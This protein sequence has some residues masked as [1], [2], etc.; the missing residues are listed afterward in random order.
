MGRT[1]RTG[2][3]MVLVVAILA[4]AIPALTAP[5]VRAQDW[6]TADAA[7]EVIA[8]SA[9]LLPQGAAEAET[10]T[11]VVGDLAPVAVGARVTISDDGEAMLT[12]FE[13]GESRL[14]A[15]TVVEV[16]AFET[17]ADSRRITVN[18]LSGQMLNSV[19]T[20]IDAESRFEVNTPAA[21]ASV[22]GTQ[23]GV[24]AREGDLTQVVTLEG[25]VAVTAGD[26]TVDLLP[27]YGVRALPDEG[28]GPVRVW[29]MGHLVI[30]A[31]VEDTARLPVTLTN[32]DNGQVFY[33]RAGDAMMPVMLGAYDVV[34]HTPGPA[35]VRGV[36]FPPET[37]AQQVVDIPVALGAVAIR[38][39]DQDGDPI[40]D[41][42]RLIV[43]LRQGELSGSTVAEPGVPI[44]A[45]PGEWDVT[46]ALESDPE[47]AI[48][49][50]LTVSPDETLDVVVQRAVF[51]D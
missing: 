36:V 48:S 5:Q 8:G 45:G 1:E 17:N 30:S 49:L 11:L 24:F 26:Q 9:T 23:F 38:L 13:G 4:S 50:T 21:S 6:E 34:L 32:L 2:W 44:L 33:Y 40:A 51:G 20:I 16:T 18:L 46:I 42:G 27:G 7:L 39:V 12:F 15:G 43:Y 47:N 22:R 10:Q 31:P 14:A 19:S 28:L 37:E 3:V 35:A 25:V 29:G 41:A